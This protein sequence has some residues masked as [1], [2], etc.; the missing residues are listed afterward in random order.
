MLGSCHLLSLFY[1]TKLEIEF[2]LDTYI[3]WDQIL[4]VV[5]YTSLPASVLDNPNNSNLK[6]DIKRS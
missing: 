1:S 5:L 2:E 3:K 4:L 6:K